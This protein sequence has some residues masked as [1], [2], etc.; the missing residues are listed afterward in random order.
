MR[1]FGRRVT[2]KLIFLT[3][4]VLKCS[5]LIEPN[6]FY[7]CP[8]S[9]LESLLA[10]GNTIRMQVNKYGETFGHNGFLKGNRSWIYQGCDCSIF[11]PVYY[12]PIVNNT[13]A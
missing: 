6:G 13:L 3:T 11:P 10:T 12:I 7:E 2:L 4:A 1:T 9:A 5:D 8:G